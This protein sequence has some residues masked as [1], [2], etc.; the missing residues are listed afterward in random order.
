[1]DL[2]RPL[3]IRDVVA[4][5]N[6]MLAP[7]AGYTDV[8]FRILARRHGAGFTS[9]EQVGAG[10]LPRDGHRTVLRAVVD[11]RERPVMLQLITREANEAATA[12]RMVAGE[13][14]QP[15]PDLLGLNMGCPAHQVQRA[16]CGAILLDRPEVA[17]SLVRAVKDAAPQP[18]VVKM[19]LGNAA[20]I[21]T[22]AFARRM[23]D[24]GADALIVHGRAAC[25]G[26]SGRADWNAIAEIVR[27]V[28]VPVVANG[29]VVDGRSAADCLRTT[30]AA[31]VALGRAALGDPAIFSRVAR[32]LA[33]G[34]FV[35]PDRDAQLEDLAEYVRLAVAAGIPEP[36]L[37]KQAQRFTK[38]I[39]DAKRVRAA[40]TRESLRDVD[41]LVGQLR[42][43][44]AVAA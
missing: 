11:G 36:S 19:R 35:A 3:R 8:A 38:G 15:R 12:A 1:M 42:G 31:G 22:R 5:N 21:D 4:E 33:D 13:P 30:G 14:G 37:L 26:Y 23:V 29:D 27:A 28:D 6:V 10:S 2:L 34:T 20:R 18:L 41:R 43:E 32:Y 17:E 9:T 16:G 24:A 44:A 40:L 7:M 39:P 25:D